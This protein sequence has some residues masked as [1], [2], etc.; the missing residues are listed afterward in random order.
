MSKTLPVNP[1]L[2]A[3]EAGLR[4]VDTAKPGFT[5][6]RAGRGFF[7]RDT[8]GDKI[9]NQA[10]LK[11]IR[12]LVIPPAW[13]E[14]WICPSPNGHIQA[15]GKDERGRKQY[16]YHPRWR[17]FRDEAKYDRLIDFAEMLPSIRQRVDRELS[18]PGLA[19]EKVIAAVV[20]LLEKTLIRI[21]N[22]SYAKENHSFGL[23]TLRD[24]HA[25][26]HGSTITFSFK[27]KSGVEHNVD[28]TD[29]RLARIIKQTQELPGQDL[30]QYI[31]DTGEHQP[32]SSDDV[33]QF[34]KEVTGQDFTAK[35]FRTWAGTVLA[36][37]ELATFE[38][39]SST[40]AAN[41]D[42]VAAIDAV[43]KQ[44]GNTRAICRACYVHPEILEAYLDHDVVSQ[45]DAVDLRPD[46]SP[47][48]KTDLSPQEK[49][50]LA[51]LK[52]RAKATN[53]N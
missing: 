53:R 7:Y 48:G 18:K 17:E 11:R 52:R 5:R 16:I 10:H 45:S 38:P 20:S 28:L 42:I 4:Y 50:V 46:D 19:R 29:R 43:A 24:R 35:D 6:H 44:L 36:A 22:E 37:S 32:V 31:D 51:F 26:I 25:A 30:V 15:T 1:E 33:N 40:T 2:S 21:G 13:N 12:A 14:V 8:H 41:K 39:P 49:E 27:G 23:T 3:R 9:E 47:L 34:L